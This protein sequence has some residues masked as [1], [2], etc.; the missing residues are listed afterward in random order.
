[1]HPAVSLVK[2]SLMLFRILLLMYAARRD[3]FM[4]IKP[5]HLPTLWDGDINM[6]FRNVFNYVKQ[7]SRK[8]QNLLTG[9][10]CNFVS[11]FMQ[12]TLFLNFTSI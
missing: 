10:I 12:Y 2:I 7:R 9:F 4:N 5:T 1:M 6:M 3:G 8:S 11:S